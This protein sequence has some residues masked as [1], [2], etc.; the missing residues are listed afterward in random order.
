VDSEI[1]IDQNDGLGVSEAE[2]SLGLFGGG[3][4]EW[5]FDCPIVLSFDFGSGSVVS[6]RIREITPDIIVNRRIR[7]SVL[8]HWKRCSH[9]P[10]GVPS[11][12]G[13]KLSIETLPVRVTP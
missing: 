7:L 3:A 1:V 12:N 8:V 13:R 6:E 9:P 2:N 4:R 11:T 10:L 5:V